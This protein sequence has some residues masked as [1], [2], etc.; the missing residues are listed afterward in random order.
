MHL[1]R[2]QLKPAEER[3]LNSRKSIV[4][5]LQQANMNTKGEATQI[6]VNILARRLWSKLVLRRGK[7][8]ARNNKN[9]EHRS[10]AT[11]DVKANLSI[12]VDARRR[13]GDEPPHLKAFKRHNLTSLPL[14]AIPGEF[15]PRHPNRQV[16]ATL[17]C[18]PSYSPAS[19]CVTPPRTNSSCTRPIL[20]PKTAPWS[21]KRHHRV[22]LV[23]LADMTMSHQ[24]AP[25]QLDR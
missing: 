20:C 7:P 16:H 14:A 17:T 18:T 1:E 21:L 25:S 22:T 9:R 10:L 11:T 13:S 15:S 3:I 12:A 23:D 5:R 8:S 2:V 24:Q 19:D 6:R 4:V